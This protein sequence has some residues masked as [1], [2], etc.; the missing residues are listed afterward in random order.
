MSSPQNVL[1][2]YNCFSPP[3]LNITND[4][5]QFII[6]FSCK[7]APHYSFLPPTGIY[8]CSFF[9]SNL[10]QST[11]PFPKNTSYLSWQ[12]NPFKKPGY[13]CT[14][15]PTHHRERGWLRLD[16][17]DDTRLLNE[18]ECTLKYVCSS[19]T[20]KRAFLPRGCCHHFGVV[21][22]DVFRT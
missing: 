4:A 1:P 16:L 8:V 22:V 6:F 7:I 10:A 11:C 5:N 2:P 20:I 18:S 9:I 13:C 12:R 14:L 17:A 19:R 21:N 3:P 15:Y